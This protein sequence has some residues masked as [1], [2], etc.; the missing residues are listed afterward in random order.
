VKHIIGAVSVLALLAQAGWA[1]D[2]VL[3]TSFPRTSSFPN[4]FT[5]GMTRYPNIDTNEDGIP[6]VPVIGYE[7]FYLDVTTMQVSART[8][9]FSWSFAYGSGAF[10]Y[11]AKMRRDGVAEFVR[12][13]IATMIQMVLMM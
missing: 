1:Q 12:C 6:E 9:P 10:T 7:A 8:R 3:K 2:I 5:F 4:N 13:L 11:V